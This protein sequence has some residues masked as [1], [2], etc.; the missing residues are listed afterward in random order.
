MALTELNTKLLRP[1]LCEGLTSRSRLHARLAEALERP[2][3]LI[4]A[5]SGFGKTTLLADWAHGA[6]APAPAWLSLDEGDN[7]PA[8]FMACLTALLEQLS[9]GMGEPVSALLALRPMPPL[10]TFTRAAIDALAATSSRCVAILDDYHAITATA[11]H[12]VIATLVERAPTHFRIILMART[13]PALPLARWRAQGLLSELDAEEMRFT[14]AEAAHFL[15]HAMPADAPQGLAATIAQRAA[16]RI[17]N[18]Q[19]ATL[20]LRAAEDELAPIASTPTGEPMDATGI[21]PTAAPPT[22]S[23]PALIENFT[24]DETTFFATF[25][26]ETLRRL[27]VHV[28]RFLIRTSILSQLT[29]PLCDSVLADHTTPES[30]APAGQSEELLRQLVEE[31]LFTTSL[32]GEPGWFRYHPLFADLLRRFIDPANRTA[33]HLRAAAWLAANGLAAQAIEHALAAGDSAAAADV[34]ERAVP[35][36]EARDEFGT[37]RR[38]LRVLPDAVVN[39]RT[40][41]C[42]ARAYV[43]LNASEF[44]S[45]KQW[46][47]RAVSLLG[48]R[49][50]GA[51]TPPDAAAAT[52]LRARVDAVLGALSAREQD[53]SQAVLLTQRSFSQWPETDPLS[54]AHVALD[55]G[56]AKLNQGDYIGAAEAFSHSVQLSRE[57]GSPAGHM[58]ALAGL[59]RVNA[60]QGLFRR[61][62]MAL[63]DAL[64]EDQTWTARVGQSL[65]SS[66]PPLILLA[67][68]LREWNRLDQARQFAEDG[69][70]R[71]QAW[72][73]QDFIFDGQIE[74][75]RVHATRGEARAARAIMDEIEAGMARHAQ[76]SSS[77]RHPARPPARP[78][79]AGL[80]RQLA[81]LNNLRAYLWMLEDDHE[82]VA[83]WVADRG[84]RVDGPTLDPDA[85]YV[86]AWSL[87]A[88]RRLDEALSGLQRLRATCESR[89]WHRELAAV[90][91]L[92]AC[93]HRLGGAES[94]ARLSL[95][96]ALDLA[97]PEGYLRVFLDPGACMAD[98]LRMVELSESRLDAFRQQVLGAFAGSHRAT[99]PNVAG[100][101]P[102]TVAPS[103]HESLT[104][105]EIA[106]LRLIAEG[107]SDESIARRLMISLLTVK[108]HTRSIYSKLGVHGR[109][110]AV[111]K[112]KTLGLLPGPSLKF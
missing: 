18:L 107:L 56:D 4:A 97:E 69:L 28:R 87:I 58:L 52:S 78:P 67:G 100:G 6:G 92:E 10:S 73:R 45:G 40:A 70:R 99:R 8:R 22:D 89:E 35:L 66:G 15:Q 49:G 14:T 60:R 65:P 34:V 27:P 80:Q 82:S 30:P 76:V 31:R 77:A 96:R 108:A 3:T 112:A 36:L 50:K 72:G 94:N 61:A 25:A 24:G 103:A 44:K 41:L 1:A 101:Q 9:P 104:P 17:A 32:N 12:Q 98:T 46:V 64:H 59:G 39:S 37:L 102:P 16:G 19:V 71:C 11:I 2:L 91:A 109:A 53:Y 83:R 75:A 33:L 79:D 38:C 5:P 48:A 43:H 7:D 23:I 62:E 105:R 86:L 54:R 90:I 29:G 13:A 42:L 111:A 81:R 57:G 93:A 110:P 68:V 20:A 63:R 47:L 55:L 95:R 74:L 106:V 85:A 51:S 26:T 88:H 84:L 21:A